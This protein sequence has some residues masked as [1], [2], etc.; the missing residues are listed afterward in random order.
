MF[1]VHRLNGAGLAKA[2]QISATF[3]ETLRQLETVCTP[4]RELSIVRTKL[5]EACFFAKRA[6]ALDPKNQEP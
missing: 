4:G 2:E 3:A 1:E 6:M 5:E